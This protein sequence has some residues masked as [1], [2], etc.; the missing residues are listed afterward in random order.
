MFDEHLLRLELPLAQQAGQ[1]SPV[2]VR[3]IRVRRVRAHREGSGEG[4]LCGHVTHV[5]CMCVQSCLLTG[6]LLL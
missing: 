4:A 3:E 2:G 6:I 5:C 1:L